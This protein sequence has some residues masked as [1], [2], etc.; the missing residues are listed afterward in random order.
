MLLLANHYSIQEH[1]VGQL[2]LNQSITFQNFYDLKLCTR[3]S[4]YGIHTPHLGLW[5]ASDCMKSQTDIQTIF[6][7]EK[8]VERK[9]NSW[10]ITDTSLMIWSRKWQ[11]TTVFLPGESQGQRGLTGYN[12]WACRESDIT[13]ATECMSW[14]S[15]GQDSAL[16]MQRAWVQ[17]LVRE[18]DPECHN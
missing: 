1:G 14:W 11:P 18:L 7:W 16:P 6:E 13:E 8:W 5:M 9:T 4:F 2:S 10:N 12:P 3:Q 15:S 17:S